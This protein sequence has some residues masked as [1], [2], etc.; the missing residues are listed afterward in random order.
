MNFDSKHQQWMYAAVHPKALVLCPENGDDYL[1]VFDVLI[2]EKSFSRYVICPKCRSKNIME[3]KNNPNPGRTF[4]RISINDSE[5]SYDDL[6]EMS[7]E[8]RKKEGIE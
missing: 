1:V 6:I 2:D 8:A 4:V 5:Y 7:I 3:V